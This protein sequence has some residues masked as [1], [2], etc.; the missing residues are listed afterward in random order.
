MVKMLNPLKM[1]DWE[2]NKF[3]TVI[4]TI[5]IS[6]LSL[7]GLEFIGIKISILRELVA[8]IYLL[9]VPGVLILRVLRLHK[10]NNI[11][12]LL[13]TVGLSISS[14]MVLGFFINQIYPLFGISKPLSLQYLIITITG[15]V[16]LLSILSYF[17]D[18][19]FSAP[20]FIDLN[21]LISPMFLF[22][23]LMPFLAIF[24]TYL[25]NYYKMNIILLVL[26]LDIALIVIL[27]AFDKL[28]KKLY[29]FCIFVIAISLLYS[30]SLISMN[31][32]EWAD[33]S[34]EYSLA[35]T[36]LM[37]SVWNPQQNLVTSNLNSILSVTLL[38]PIYSIISSIN[39]VWLFKLYFPLIYSLM[40]VGL[41]EVFKRQTDSKTAFVAIFFFISTVS[42]FSDMLG[43]VRQQFAELFLCMILL[44]LV[45]K[46]INPIKST[47][48]LIVFSI[49]LIL[50]HYALSYILMLILI[51]TGVLLFIS[52]RRNLQ[53]ETRIH[54]ANLT[55]GFITLFIVLTFSWYMYVSNSTVIV[56]ITHIGSNMA[57]SLFTEF[58]NPA[59]TQ[60]LD[61]VVKQTQ[62]TLGT[63]FKVIYFITQFFILIGVLGA[64]LKLK[65][66]FSKLNND[67]ILLCVPF[68]LMDLA[69]ILIPN[70][71]STINTSRL[72]HISLITLALLGVIGGKYVFSR[73]KL[74]K[75]IIIKILSL[76]FIVY[77]LFNVGVIYAL[78]GQNNSFAL[79]PDKIDRPH[80]A[81]VDINSLSWLNSHEAADKKVY[82]D[83][84]Y[85]YLLEI[86]FNQFNYLEYENDN[87][88][89]EM[90]GNKNYIF[91][92]QYDISNN[93]IIL[94]KDGRH[95]NETESLGNFPILDQ[96]N[97]I[98]DNNAQL[99]L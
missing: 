17:I 44:L 58:L 8:F 80:F 13:Y 18:K 48:L 20:D 92:G 75:D 65:N 62:S 36:V 16:V 61:I 5:Q 83:S 57:G 51:L 50:S 70:F 49:S 98:Y 29:P 30:N 52:K 77:F 27:M 82:A 81:D 11:E 72:Y 43:L 88:K 46:R 54:G 23:C 24:G 74:N 26:F 10:L 64:L 12:A 42:F 55:F 38:T 71:A 41:Y 85:A 56:S 34:F 37:N 59:S 40:P 66:G 25:V 2:I 7:I 68:F 96:K 39:I 97:K 76:F 95:G 99:F 45:N 19:D 63:I 91:L 86:V 79:N 35:H 14:L 69:G 33:S 84:Y 1:N 28:P 78:A 21:G 89:L 47:V 4:F 73:L 90:V 67:Y 60:G 93:K 15:F 94:A 9:F 22:L 31:L 6:L 32:V 53:Y 3:L 87:Y